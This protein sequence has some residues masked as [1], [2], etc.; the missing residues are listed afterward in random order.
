MSKIA[1]PELKLNDGGS[2]PTIGFGTYR[3]DGSSGVEGIVSALRNGYRLQDSVFNYE[4]EG[5]LGVAIRKAGVPREELVVTSKL[6][7]CHHH[8]DEAIATV[9]ES[10][11]RARLD[12]Y[13][14]YLT[15]GKTQHGLDRSSIPWRRDE[16]A[17][18][19]FRHQDGMRLVIL[20][21]DQFR[22]KRRADHPIGHGFPA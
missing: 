16:G 1:I 7:G 9:E 19:V 5:P 14:L 13:D 8:F 2:I 20:K 22:T 18:Q 15:F 3:I 12:Y 21:V 17:G 10:L 4:N 11:Y 6:P